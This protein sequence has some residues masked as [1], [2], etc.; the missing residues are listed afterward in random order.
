MADSEPSPDSTTDSTGGDQFGAE[1]SQDDPIDGTAPVDDPGEYEST[2]Q[3]GGQSLDTGV[4]Y[5]NSGEPEETP[6]DIEVARADDEE[7]Q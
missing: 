5:D 2:E 3:S 7:A 6:N 1:H 4:S